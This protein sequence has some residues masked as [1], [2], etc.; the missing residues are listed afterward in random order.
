MPHV[1][2]DIFRKN[3]GERKA[4][5]ITLSEGESIAESIAAAMMEHNITEAKIVD[6]QGTIQEG[7]VMYLENGERRGAS[8]KNQQ[9]NAASGDVKVNAN[10]L[11]GDITINFGAHRPIRGILQAGK[12]AEGL[13]I[14]LNF[15]EDLESE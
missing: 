13:E 9:V 15:Y 2:S 11:W 14:R 1:V 8:V 5:I 7:N 12:A 6:M 10:E 4:L 3:K